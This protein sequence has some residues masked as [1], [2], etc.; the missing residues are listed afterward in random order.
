M[1]KNYFIVFPNDQK[2]PKVG[3]IFKVV[4]L[5]PD[6]DNDCKAKLVI[7]YIEKINENDENQTNKTPQSLSSS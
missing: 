1:S 4:E 7:C 3:D 6:Y 5:E 2:V